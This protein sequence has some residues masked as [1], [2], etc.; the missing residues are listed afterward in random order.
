MVIIIAQDPQFQKNT[1]INSL[2]TW[3]LVSLS[4]ELAVT[5]FMGRASESALA[6]EELSAR[7]TVSTAVAH[8]PFWTVHSQL[9]DLISILP[10]SRAGCSGLLGL[11][12]VRIL[13]TED[14]ANH[15]PCFLAA[16]TEHRMAVPIVTRSTL[17]RQD[18]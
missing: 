16:N 18:Q 4:G 3:M 14:T 17:T 11:A 8:A 5:T 1:T 12:C 9:P 15:K 10:T 13:A 7:Q 2:L 6:P